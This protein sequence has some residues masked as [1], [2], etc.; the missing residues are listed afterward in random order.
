MSG[1]DLRRFVG[2]P[3]PNLSRHV[4]D[5]PPGGEL[6]GGPYANLAP[7]PRPAALLRRRDAAAGDDALAP[8][9]A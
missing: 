2:G 9:P 4:A 6:V 5:A 7:A 1:A 8:L 3:F